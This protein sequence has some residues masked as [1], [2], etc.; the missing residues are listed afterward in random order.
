VITQ[1]GILALIS[2]TSTVS[3]ARTCSTTQDWLESAAP[4]DSVI[5]A[6]FV[7]MD[8]VLKS[9]GQSARVLSKPAAGIASGADAAGSWLHLPS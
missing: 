9:G 7:A 2:A 5:R 8:Q 6:V 1:S 4:D 3:A